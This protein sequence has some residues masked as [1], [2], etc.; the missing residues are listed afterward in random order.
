VSKA[1]TN[2]PEVLTS[3]V[4]FIWLENQTASGTASNAPAKPATIGNTLAPY[5]VDYGHGTA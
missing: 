1:L 3:H 2:L 5:E 4:I